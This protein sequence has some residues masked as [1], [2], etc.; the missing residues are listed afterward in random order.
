MSKEF[1]QYLKDNGIKH[2]TSVAHCPQSNGKAERLNLTLLMK[3]RCMLNCAKVDYKLW[4]AAIDTANYLRNRSPSSI[5][6]GKTPYEQ[7]FGKQPKIK[8][9]RV[10]GCDAYPLN[11]N[12]GKNKFESRAI[13]NCIMIWYGGSEGIY[14]IFNKQN[15]QIFRSRDVKF[16]EESILEN[17]DNVRISIDLDNKKETEPKI[18]LQELEIE[19][20]NNQSEPI[21]DPENL[22][23]NLD[24]IDDKSENS[25]QPE[26]ENK[27]DSNDI[28]DTNTA[29][30]SNKVSD[31]EKYN[32]RARENLNKKSKTDLSEEP[33]KRTRKQTQRYKPGES[34]TQLQNLMIFSTMAENIEDEP[35]TFEE[36]LNSQLKD[37]WKHA[38]NSELNS[39]RENDTWSE[40]TLPFDK[41]AIKTRWLFK[42]K[43]DSNNNPIRLK[44]LLVAKGYEQE[45]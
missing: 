33:I 23:N 45:K 20:D 28:T 2:Q 29:T 24:E 26:N 7:L 21:N 43:R 6:N 16:N 42:I 1:E 44:A 40:A 37:K 10:F 39:L 36:A 12:A 41:N 14:W 9:L 30:S 35:I 8:H 11:L 19:T 5:L 27:E 15:N 18:E 25:V 31:K 3:A 4:T 38:I 17:Q 22:N 13:E 32:L 34:M